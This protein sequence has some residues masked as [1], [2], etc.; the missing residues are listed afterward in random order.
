MAVS[1]A[2]TI[3][4]VTLDLSSVGSGV[5]NMSNIF[6]ATQW[7]YTYLVPSG[8]AQGTK[9]I[10]VSVKDDNNFSQ[11]GNIALQIESISLTTEMIFLDGDGAASSL[12]PPGFGG[13]QPFPGGTFASVT[14]TGADK[15][16]GANSELFSGVLA[17]KLRIW[18][19][20]DVK[21]DLSENY[22]LEFYLKQA[23]GIATNGFSLQLVSTSNDAFG[24]FSGYYDVTNVP[25]TW[26]KISVP[27]SSFGTWQSGYFEVINIYW[28]YGD[29]DFYIDDM[30]FTTAL[31][32]PDAP[33]FISATTFDTNEIEVIWN[34]LSNETG[35]T[36][37]RSDTSNDTNT[38]NF[39][40]Q[41]PSDTTTYDDV[42]LSKGTWY[43]YWLKGYNLIGGSSFSAVISNKTYSSISNIPPVLISASVSPTSIFATT[44]IEDNTVVFTVFASSKYT[45][46]A[47]VTLD[48]TPLNS[49]VVNMSNIG[50]ST[51]WRYSYNVPDSVP[52]GT[53]NIPVSVID[54]FSNIVTGNIALEVK[55]PYPVIEMLFLD[56][57]AASSAG[58]IISGVPTISVT[59]F[60]PEVGANCELLK[61]FGGGILDVNMPG[62]EIWDITVYDSLDFYIKLANTTSS[63]DLA[64]QIKDNGGSF[65]SIIKFY[66][67]TTNWTKVSLPV[68]G[69]FIGSANPANLQIIRFRWDFGDSDF[70]IDDMKFVGPMPVPDAPVFISA[71]SPVAADEMLVS[72]I[73]LP[74]ETAYTLFRNVSNTTDTITFKT[75]LLQN[76]ITYND[77]G[78]TIDTW[79]YYWLKA[80]NPAG[81]SVFSAIIS[82]KTPA[83]IS[84]IPPEIRSTSVI[85]ATINSNMDIL[86][87]FTVNAASATTNIVNVTLELSNV[88]SGLVNMN[89]ISGFTQWEYSYTVPSGLS[90]GT[91][92]I[93]VSVEDAYGNITTA[94]IALEIIPGLVEDKIFLDGD[95]ASSF[96][97]GVQGA[98]TISISSIRPKVGANCEYIETPVADKLKVWTPGGVT[99]DVTAHPILTLWIRGATSTD[100]NDLNVQF[101]SK[102]TNDADA[103]SAAFHANNTIT[104]ITTNWMKWSITFASMVGDWFPDKFSFIQFH[105]GAGS[106][107]IDD[108]RFSTWPSTPVFVSCESTS[109]NQIDLRWMGM[110]N[111]TVYTLFR[112]TTNLAAN[113]TFKTQL[114]KGTTAYSDIGLAKNTLYYYWLKAYNSMGVSAFSSVIFAKTVA[115]IS[116]IPPDIKNASVNPNA[117]YNTMASLIEI[118]VTALSL[119]TNIVEVTVDLTPINLGVVYMNN[120]SGAT[121][122]QY[123]CT[124][125]AGLAT[126]TKYL[127]VSVKDG[128]DNISKRN[129]SL[130]IDPP[131]LESKVFLDGDEASSFGRETKQQFGT[132]TINVTNYNPKVGNNCE[133]FKAATGDCLKVYMP[134]S[135]LWDVRDCVSL[136]LWVKWGSVVGTNGISIQ[137]ITK[138][139]GGDIYSAMHA[140]E[141][142][143]T[144]WMK[145]SLPFSGIIGNWLPEGLSYLQLWGIGNGGTCFIDDMKFVSP[146]VPH[147]P[148]TPSFIEDSCIPLSTNVIQLQWNPMLNTTGYSLFRGTNANINSTNFKIDLLDTIYIDNTGLERNTWYYYWLKAYNEHGSSGLSAMLDVKTYSNLCYIEPVIRE[149]STT[150]S[151]V[152]NY[153]ENCVTFYARVTTGNVIGWIDYVELDLTPLGIGKRKVKMVDIS[154]ATQWSYTCIIPENAHNHEEDLIITT[155]DSC[156]NPGTGKIEF[157]IISKYDKMIETAQIWPNYFKVPGGSETPAGAAGAIDIEESDYLDVVV[158]VK[159]NQTR[160][161]VR[162]YNIAGEL[163]R[164][165]VD[166][167]FDEGV[168]HPN[169]Y[170]EFKWDLRDDNNNSCKSGVYIVSVNI[171]DE[172]PVLKK[173]IFIR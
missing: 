62:N 31:P 110:N 6:G 108:M 136:D 142:I 107:F 67:F 17:E 126:G 36:L 171:N 91:K 1:A 129:L 64:I 65:G 86:V 27:V 81:A 157:K 24:N 7:R 166:D 50:S 79:Y 8:V 163:V 97:R 147:P 148:Y 35:Y 170:K 168:L 158:R 105:L 124:V 161:K 3:T 104:G 63:N 38:I 72:W 151:T 14:V 164:N 88:N 152:T 68:D 145:I 52:E 99:W 29:C 125:S 103:Y 13:I 98:P 114:Q 93:H 22:T 95:E 121:Q 20:N 135:V 44:N 101:I 85:P 11:A 102:D 75:Q 26:T 165:L 106:Y 144:N 92:N 117:I 19:T 4:N 139:N 2:A 56:G 57:D 160:V 112:N 33:V 40:T 173:V 131:I 90:T 134:G 119:V 118:N 128:F 96:G 83:S 37:F 156:G 16:I 127:T 137:F 116:N 141:N 9:N 58:R 30:K 89:N 10:A 78:L 12:R 51:Q 48:L 143:T 111:E 74:N 53:T 130:T 60:K 61:G 153:K 21:W 45:N 55:Y 49:A 47:N 76:I 154:G 41:L 172:K 133:A 77:V 84:E 66:N 69:G 34:D 87:E 167:V 18:T 123:S 73:D 32:T 109:T 146:D 46:I 15:V 113:F 25:A 42:A 5:V 132:P 159:E 54:A 71:Y 162:I 43:Y 82:N 122:W 100:I 149:T 140:F 70:Y 80:Y 39:K 28:G 169:I 115:N 59:N 94:N 138:T 155:M 120:I 150:P 23:P